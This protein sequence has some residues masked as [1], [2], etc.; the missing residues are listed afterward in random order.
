MWALLSNLDSLSETAHCLPVSV[1]IT[2]A[3]SPQKAM[4]WRGGSRQ[5]D[6]GTKKKQKMSVVHYHLTKPHPSPSG[7]NRCLSF[8]APLQLAEDVTGSG[9]WNMSRNEQPLEVEWKAQGQSPTFS[10]KD[11]GQQRAPFIP[12]GSRRE[13]GLP[14]PALGLG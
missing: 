10:C 1:E 5:R 12:S 3:F 8:P 4:G 2:W 9:Q 14:S 7:T 11:K 13:Q 6:L